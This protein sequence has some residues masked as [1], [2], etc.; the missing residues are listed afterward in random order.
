M[1]STSRVLSVARS[2]AGCRQRASDQVPRGSERRSEEAE[3]ESAEE[4]AQAERHVIEGQL[5]EHH[6]M[7]F[8]GEA[9][10]G[11]ALPPDASFVSAGFM[12]P[13]IFMLSIFMVSSRQDEPPVH[14]FRAS[15]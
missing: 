14:L 6:C 13:L 11:T 7:P 4:P 5:A 12:A 10:C 3:S 15:W 9:R 2:A 8:I 1:A